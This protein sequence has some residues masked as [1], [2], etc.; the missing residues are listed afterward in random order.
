MDQGFE[1]FNIAYLLGKGEI[2]ALKYGDFT[3][4]SYYGYF[5]TG[6]YSYGDLAAN[7]KG[8]QFWASITGNYKPTSQPLLICENN[9]W[10]KNYE[11]KWED[12][13]DALLD[14]GVNCVE[15]SIFVWKQMY[16]S[17]LELEAADPEHR[18]ICPVDLEQCK[19]Y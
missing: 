3:E 2:A 12:H 5:G 10:V 9:Q 16:A 4:S 14:E 15:Q 6:I 18:Y 17:F 1:Y 7:Y 11:F 19:Y 8:M 13:V